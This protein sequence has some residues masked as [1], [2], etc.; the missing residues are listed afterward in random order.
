MD[1]F[2]IRGGQTSDMMYGINASSL[3]G[4][5][6]RSMATKVR[7]ECNSLCSIP[8]IARSPIAVHDVLRS[9]IAPYIQFYAVV[10]KTNIKVP[11]RNRKMTMHGAEHRISYRVPTLG[12][13]GLS[14][15][16]T[17]VT[18]KKMF[19]CTQNQPTRLVCFSC[20]TPED[21]LWY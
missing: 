13:G 8:H 21:T 6:E 1:R 16:K 7:L 10:P 9:H 14:G 11:Q 15:K 12:V 20:V 3:M 4:L 19:I 2:G 18:H 5:L 17:L